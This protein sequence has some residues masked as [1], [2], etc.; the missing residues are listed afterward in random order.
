MRRGAGAVRTAALLIPLA[1][2]AM[3]GCSD[4]E[5]SSGATTASTS[6]ESLLACPAADPELLVDRVDEAVAAVEAELGG[7]QQYF[8]IDASLTFV[9]VIV[10]AEGGAEAVRYR[11]VPGE[12]LD[13]EPMGEAQGATF[14][15][16]DVGYDP[17]R[18]LSCVRTELASS[19]IDLLEVLGSGSGGA[20]YTVFVTS[21]QGGQL[22][23]QV[24]ATGQVQ[25]V[26]PI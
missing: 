4:D 19:T 22:A 26:D 1:L 14:A 25:A 7:A 21:A 6:A 13:V 16:D 24:S 18:V 23:V 12:P 5:G 15:A 20:V 9:N 11:W 2:L 3:S 10:A 8:E 17:E